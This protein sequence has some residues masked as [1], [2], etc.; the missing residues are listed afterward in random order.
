MKRLSAI[1]LG[2]ICCACFGSPT[3]LAPSLGGTVGVP[4][5]GAQTGAVQLPKRGA[6][7][8]RFRKNSP[9]YWGVPRLIA[10][11]ETA[12]RAVQEKLPGGQPLLVGDISA[13]HG[14]KIPGHRSHRTGRDVD[15][16]WYVTT[17]AG[18]PIKNRDFVHVSTDGLAKVHGG[19]DD[20]DEYVRL[21]VER[22]WQLVKELLLAPD[23]NIQWIFA[24][25]SV[26]ALIIDYAR[27]RG[28]DDEL[29]WH[30]E[31]VLLQP[32][33]SSPHDDHFHV[34][35]ACTPAEALR[36]CEGGGPYWEWLPPLPRLPGLDEALLDMIA[37]DPLDEDTGS[38]EIGE[39]GL[40]P[41]LAPPAPKR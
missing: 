38:I 12:A 22:Q 34:R 3:P 26:E 13:K 33:D 14:G 10:T 18:A 2:W 32:G 31:T 39:F 5:H 4:H 19:D 24:S 35:I 23:A 8:E 20:D 36:G 16:L 25:R 1:S 28:E 40:W 27:A 6:G 21:D 29:V 9:H 15:L 7:F 30:A 41:K 37:E 17:P 11:I